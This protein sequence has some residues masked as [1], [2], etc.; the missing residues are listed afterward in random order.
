MSRPNPL[1]ASL[2]LPESDGKRH[3]AFLEDVIRENL[4]LLFPGYTV[5]ESYT[6]RVERETELAVEDEYP[7]QLTQRI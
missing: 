3:V 2:E 4:P 1:V 7:M 5:L 6:L